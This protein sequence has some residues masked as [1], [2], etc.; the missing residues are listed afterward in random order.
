L[1]SRRVILAA[2]G[3]VGVLAIAGIVTL[4]V[5]SVTGDDDAKADA[6]TP[7]ATFPGTSGGP[8][9]SLGGPAVQYDI[10]LGDLTGR[11]DAHDANNYQLSSL[12]FASIGPFKGVSEGQQYADQW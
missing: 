8:E 11:F 12:A 10:Q 6:A 5:L 3:L 9:P 7:S 4:I 1:P 2:A